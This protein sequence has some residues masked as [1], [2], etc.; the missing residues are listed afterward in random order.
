MRVEI[1][2]IDRNFS[3]RHLTL[4]LSGLK[5]SKPEVQRDA[6]HHMMHL[7]GGL[8]YGAEICRIHFNMEEYPDE[9]AVMA[10]VLPILEKYN[11]QT[12]V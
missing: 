9:L 8:M 11:A 10:H 4:Y 5:R 2:K 7:L 12:E 1:I 3:D 6:V